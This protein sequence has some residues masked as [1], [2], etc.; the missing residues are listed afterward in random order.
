MGNCDANCGS[1]NC[2][3]N[4]GRGCECND[5]IKKEHKSEGQKVNNDNE[6]KINILNC[7][8]CVY[9]YTDVNY[10]IIL[11]DCG[12]SMCGSCASL[13]TKCP[14]CNKQIINSAVKNYALIE[15]IVELNIN[16][17]LLNN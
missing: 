3:S 8:I 17:S 4:C 7:K 10:P 14:F 1:I 2:G 13:L 5:I 11:V 12:H 9:K 6:S 15:A 16:N